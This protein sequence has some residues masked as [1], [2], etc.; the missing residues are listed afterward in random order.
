MKAAV[1]DGYGGAAAIRIA[2][3]APP[4]P[5][6]GEIGIA[7]HA[8]GLNPADWKLAEG[9]LAP[10]LTPAFPYILG[11]DAA[12]IVTAVG[13]DV[14]GHAIG[15]RVVAK[16]AVGRGGAG[17]CA[18][19]VTVAA[20]LACPLPDT[21]S[22]AEAAA[23]PTAGITA[24]E[25]LFDAGTLTDG[26]SILVNGGA[27]GTGSL[28]IQLAHMAGAR[29][30]ATAS[31]AN[32]AY[33]RLIGAKA[34]IDYR[35]DIGAA[36]R[37]HFGDRVDLLLD[38]VGQGALRRPLDMIRDGGRLVTIATLV[39]GEPRPSAEEAARRGIRI[40]TAT[41]SREREGEQLRRLVEAIGAGRIR[42]PE[43]ETAPLADIAAALARVKAGHVR[44]KIVLMIDAA[45]RG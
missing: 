14:S 27:G 19:H 15:D 11:F 23:L 4:A 35:S 39:A 26:E 32:H 43:I 8:A 21:L 1:I 2:D 34:A 30:A 22:F 36:V 12:G 20:Q 41:S 10:A 16:T 13:D 37:S 6:R 3:L 38:T 24:W 33:L 18:G 31:P 40:L 29:V 42:P 5:R 45:D 9:W 17:G 25:A 7:V 44:G 28:A